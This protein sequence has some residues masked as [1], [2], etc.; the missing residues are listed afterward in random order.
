[1]E[2][3]QSKNISKELARKLRHEESPKTMDLS[4]RVLMET[5]L[6]SM[7]TKPTENEL[8]QVVTNDSKKRFVMETLNNKVYIS[9]AQGH[10]IPLEKP[11]LTP[12]TSADIIRVA[13]HATTSQALQII[14]ESGF[15][16]RMKRNEIHI[17]TRINH[18]LSNKKNTIFLKLKLYEALNAG[19]KFMLSSNSVLLCKGPLPIEFFEVINCSDLESLNET[20]QS[21]S[22]LTLESLNE[23][24]QSQNK[25]VQCYNKN[26]HI[27]LGV[28]DGI[29][30]VYANEMLESRDHKEIVIN[31][32]FLDLKI[33]AVTK[34]Y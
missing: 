29:N 31:N 30:S 19:Y 34:K 24:V 8:V 2:S 9:A 5:L 15:L 32:V 3:L 21:A 27:T 16:K 11:I 20:V 4:G 10:T 7:K 33:N 1:M 13:V 12:V 26:P 17:A 6:K 23:T 25:T 14:Q 28:V 22:K 18:L